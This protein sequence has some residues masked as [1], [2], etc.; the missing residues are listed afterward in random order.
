MQRVICIGECM[1]ELRRTAEDFLYVGYAGDVYNTAV[2]LK[3]ESRLLDVQFAGVTGT[4]SFS[5]KMREAWQK[6]QIGDFLVAHKDDELPGLY[7]VETTD[8]GERLFHYWRSASAGKDWLRAVLDRKNSFRTTDIVYLSG[9]SLAILTPED[10]ATALTF[11]QGLKG[12]VAMLVFDP[13]YRPKLWSS[14]DHAAQAIDAAISAADIV[15]PSKE[16]L[17][18]LCSVQETEVHMK[19]LQDRGVCEA[20]ITAK[21]GSCLVLANNATAW[22]RS[23][24]AT[25]VVDTAGAGV[26]F[27]AAY[28][29]SRISG[30]DP[31]RSALAGLKLSAKV[32]GKPGAIIPTSPE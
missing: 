22:V 23:E 1:V 3:R 18:L 29:A 15:L 16:D 20:V 30:G 6:N 28:L 21:T 2:Y 11:L 24:P 4:D 19:S 5:K 9:I 32:V 26:A 7:L 13:N 12:K 10:R 27:N 31:Q 14:R 8:D 17:D 25:K